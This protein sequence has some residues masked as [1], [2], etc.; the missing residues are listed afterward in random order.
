MNSTDEHQHGETVVLAEVADE[1]I[2]DLPR[3]HAGRTARTLVS[4]T[5]Q[6]ATMIALAARGPSCS[7]SSVPA[8]SGSGRWRRAG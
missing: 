2:A 5:A 7:A 1:L 8:A 3:H 4:G 6:R